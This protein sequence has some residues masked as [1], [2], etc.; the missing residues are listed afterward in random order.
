MSDLNLL[1]QIDK[2][3]DR[4]VDEVAQELEAS[5]LKIEKKLITIGVISGKASPEKLETLK[6]VEG[7]FDLREEEALKIPPIDDNLPQ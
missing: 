2:K 7:V 1:V 3:S 4:T 6:K 5:G